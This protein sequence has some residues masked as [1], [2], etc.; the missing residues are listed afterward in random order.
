M[1]ELRTAGITAGR[2]RPVQT[3]PLTSTDAVEREW[4]AWLR[5]L[6]VAFGQVEIVPWPGLTADGHTVVKMAVGSTA[7]DMT[8]VALVVII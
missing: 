6:S 1:F 2:Q 5:T 7:H 8:A 3:F 4:S